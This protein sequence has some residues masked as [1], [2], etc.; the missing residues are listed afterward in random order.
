MRQVCSDKAKQISCKMKL[1]HWGLQNLLSLLGYVSESVSSF[2]GPPWF[3][4]SHLIRDRVI[5]G[6]PTTSFSSISP[7]SPP[8][9]PLHRHQGGSDNKREMHT[10]SPYNYPDNCMN[11]S[12]HT[13][14][15]SQDFSR[16]CRGQDSK[17]GK[18]RESC[19]YIPRLYSSV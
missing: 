10:L 18:L 12:L 5:A 6:E 14:G 11:S 1:D 13:T 7:F 3:Q 16:N 2:L 15:C 17:W 8:P 9:P 19:S 4:S